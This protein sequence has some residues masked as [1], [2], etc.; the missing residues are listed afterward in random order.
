MKIYPVFYIIYLEP[1]NNNILLKINL[2]KIDPDNQ[3]IEYKVETILD[4]QKV[5]NQPRYLIK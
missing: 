3:K 4:Q 2:P 5:D 1:A